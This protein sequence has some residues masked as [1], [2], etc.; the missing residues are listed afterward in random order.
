MRFSF[1]SATSRKWEAVIPSRSSLESLDSL[2]KWF[3]ISG[4]HVARLGTA[5]NGF[6]T[7]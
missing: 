6:G 4:C 2:V 3:A 5:Q 7:L 1:V